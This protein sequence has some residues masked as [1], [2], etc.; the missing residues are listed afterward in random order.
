MN[1]A[2]THKHT[3]THTQNC[4]H[5]T[6]FLMKE[7]RQIISKIYRMPDINKYMKLIRM[8]GYSKMDLLTTHWDSG[9]LEAVN[10][11]HPR[12]PEFLVI[13]RNKWHDEWHSFIWI[14]Q[15]KFSLKLWRRWEGRIFP[16]RLE[17]EAPSSDSGDSEAR[18]MMVLPW[19][20]LMEAWIQRKVAV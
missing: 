10:K 9:D 17:F 14:S 18:E 12:N 16:G 3:H 19:L 6:Y 20:V 1:K 8:R 7:G 11:E 5:V 13:D 4:L 2:C 15:M